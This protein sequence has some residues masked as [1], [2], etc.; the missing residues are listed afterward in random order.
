MTT[1]T[2]TIKLINYLTLILFANFCYGQEIVSINI[3]D[4]LN[5]PFEN[6]Q[7]KPS[8]IIGLTDYYEFNEHIAEIKLY[9]V[10]EEF[11]HGNF[12]E[13]KDGKFTSYNKIPCIQGTFRC[14]NGT[15]KVDGNK[16]DF[17]LSTI[18]YIKNA[19]PFK[20]INKSLGTFYWIKDDFSFRIVK[21]L[22]DEPSVNYFEKLQIPIQI[23]ED[24]KANYLIKKYIYV[25]NRYSQIID[26]KSKEKYRIMLYEFEE[27][28]TEARNY[29]TI[30]ENEQFHKLIM[31][32]D[33]ILY[34]KT[35]ETR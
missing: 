35:K 12:V 2:M 27:W 13:F 34:H 14:T 8:E 25:F 19:E 30:N 3:A 24:K 33:G 31:E 15:Y 21:D 11:P 23:F 17:F 1:N 5:N 20:T 22:K 6:S 26:N 16:I 9:P 29:K 32:L 28:R 10:N 7:W 4:K 18:S